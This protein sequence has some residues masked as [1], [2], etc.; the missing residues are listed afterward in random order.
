MIVTPT[1]NVQ[2]L[3]EHLYVRVIP[4]GGEMEK[5][6][7]PLVSSLDILL[8]PLIMPS[9]FGD[10]IRASIRR[11]YGGNGVKKIYF[12]RFSYPELVRIP[13]VD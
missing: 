4:V 13:L 1:P 3:L 10:L 8:D 7:L 9:N 2:Q 5:P 11:K 12:F 6:A